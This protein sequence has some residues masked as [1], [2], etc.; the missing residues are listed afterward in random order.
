MVQVY[1]ERVI[2]LDYVA[3]K[4]SY[5]LWFWIFR[6][7]FGAGFAVGTG[8][9]IWDVISLSREAKEPIPDLVPVRP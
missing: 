3:V 1:M 4:S 6:T 7:I 8:L 9:L 2:G 5:N